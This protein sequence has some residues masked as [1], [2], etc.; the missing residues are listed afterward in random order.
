[1][2][3]SWT[4][5]RQRASSPEPECSEHHW[6]YISRG[7]WCCNG[8]H[9]ITAPLKVRRDRPENTTPMCYDHTEH[10]D[11]LI[12]PVAGVRRLRVAG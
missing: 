2:R 3:W 12:G 10:L 6:H 11:D 5:L 1:M 9:R 4:P 7:W 8:E